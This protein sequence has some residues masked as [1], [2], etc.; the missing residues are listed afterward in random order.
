MWRP[1]YDDRWLGARN[2]SCFRPEEDFGQTV[3]IAGSW[4]DLERSCHSSELSVEASLNSSF[5]GGKPMSFR[6]PPTVRTATKTSSPRRKALGCRARNPKSLRLK[7]NIIIRWRIAS[8][9]RASPVRSAGL[10]WLL[11]SHLTV[12]GG[13]KSFERIA[14]RRSAGKNLSSN[15]ER[16]VFS[17]FHYHCLS[18]AI[19]FVPN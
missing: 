3:S 19:F 2:L 9:V 10:G 14:R 16:L 6:S 5:A 7:R 17:K 12:D 8:R 18:A 11:D 4:L 1:G 13:E 15:L